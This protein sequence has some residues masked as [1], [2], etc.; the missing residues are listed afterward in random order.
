MTNT[1]VSPVDLESFSGAPFDDVLVDVAVADIRG[2][3]GWHIAPE[4][5]ETLTLTSYGGTVLFLPT[6]KLVA[7]TA[8]RDVTTGSTVLA[9][10]TR[11]ST[12]VYRRT[13][14]P[15]GLVEVDLTHGFA[16]TPQ[17]LLPVVAARVATVGSPRDAVVGQRSTRIDDYAESE[18]YR[19]VSDP[20]VARY[21]VPSGVA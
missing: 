14:W 8:I 17:D 10:W 2:E 13:G 18:T 3:A 20:I 19:V 21:A 12:G 15:I 6:R 7:V 1:L 4:V 9:D 16:A 11:M 5:T